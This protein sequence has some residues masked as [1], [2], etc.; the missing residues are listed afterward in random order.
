[1]NEYY[2]APTT[3]GDD[4]LA[5]YG[6]KGMRW[7][8]RKARELG[9]DAMLSR[10]Y[11]KARR[12]LNKLNERANIQVQQKKYDTWRNAAGKQA[13]G[14]AIGGAVGGIL[15]SNLGLAPYGMQLSPKGMA[16]I[17]GAYGLAGGLGSYA[18]TRLRANVYKKRI[19][20]EGHAKAIAK[21]NAWQKEMDSA[22]KGTRYGRNPMT[23]GLSKKQAKQVEQ[24]LK[25][26]VDSFE[27]HYQ[28][29]LSKG[30]THEQAERYSNDYIAK[31]G[32]KPSSKKRRT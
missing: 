10:H 15:G 21:R 1:M 32:F 23:N 17:G 26:W 7:G 31:H 2:G 18:G 20:P 16:L 19:S 14:G 8:V 30:M 27:K 5:H 12:K 4:Y 13:A 22:F 25:N 6:V 28:T 9:S 24:G 11:D 29:G 3:P